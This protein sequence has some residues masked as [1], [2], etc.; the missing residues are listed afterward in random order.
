MR[1]I[2]CLIACAVLGGCFC[3]PWIGALCCV[4][5]GCWG[6]VCWLLYFVLDMLWLVALVCG[7]ACR[8][9]VFGYC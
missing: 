9:V 4:G 1:V 7:F 8:F 6:G 5:F 2:G 3:V